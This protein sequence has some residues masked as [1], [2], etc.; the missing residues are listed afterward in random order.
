MEVYFDNKT[1]IVDSIYEGYDDVPRLGL[2][3]HLH[4]WTFPEQTGKGVGKFRVEI[5]ERD[6][7]P[8]RQ[9]VGIGFVEVTPESVLGATGYAPLSQAILDGLLSHEVVHQIFIE[10]AASSLDVPLPE[11]K[12]PGMEGRRKIPEKAFH[13]P[14]L[15]G[16]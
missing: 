5:R 6:T 3:I 15:H 4:G 14:K 1:W 2:S 16:Y 13:N 12:K 9:T 10:A 11:K 7:D 8:S